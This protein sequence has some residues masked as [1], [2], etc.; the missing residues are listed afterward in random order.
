MPF[1]AS[2]E[3]PCDALPS[4]D[5][6]GRGPV[7]GGGGG[8]TDFEREDLLLIALMLRLSRERKLFKWMQRSRD[9]SPAEEDVCFCR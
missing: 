4:P 9:V 1:Q 2:G 5:R 8:E 6:C 7:S 3:H